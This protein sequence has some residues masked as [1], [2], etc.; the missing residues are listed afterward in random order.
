MLLCSQP[1]SSHPGF[2]H[3][4]RQSVLM[5]ILPE[6]E[7]RSN[8]QNSPKNNN[9]NI[10]LNMCWI[11]GSAR[12]CSGIFY[13][14]GDWANKRRSPRKKKLQ[15]LNPEASHKKKKK[16]CLENS[17]HSLHVPGDRRSV[18]PARS[19]SPETRLL[20]NDFPSP[21]SEGAPK[22]QM[23]PLAMVYREQR[24]CRGSSCRGCSPGSKS[25]VFMS[26]HS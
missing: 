24:C 26:K 18:C 8:I 5:Q 10:I 7:L 21:L 22:R 2:T 3:C 6:I 9:L 11:Y 19:P 13:F 15:T 12:L 17:E 16:N 20:C 4:S 25:M 23:L 14:K 1:S